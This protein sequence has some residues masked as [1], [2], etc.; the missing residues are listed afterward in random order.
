VYKAIIEANRKR[1]VRLDR[2]PTVAEW[3][4]R[5]PERWRLACQVFAMNVNTPGGITGKTLD[6]IAKTAN[7]KGVRMSRSTLVRALPHLE[8]HGVVR[9]ERHSY[10]LPTGEMRRS[11]STWLIGLRSRMPDVMPPPFVAP[12]ADHEARNDSWLRAHGLSKDIEAML[13]RVAEQP[14]TPPF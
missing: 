1:R 5:Q 2:T 10:R 14:V 3:V 4:E 13:A 6:Q 9:Q 8:R 7:D 11:P 12:Q